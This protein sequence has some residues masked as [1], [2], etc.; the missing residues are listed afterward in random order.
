MGCCLRSAALVDDVIFGGLR[1]E[2]RCALVPKW[3][4]P[5]TYRCCVKDKAVREVLARSKAVSEDEKQA[6]ILTDQR[7]PIRSSGKRSQENNTL[8]SIGKV[9]L[10]AYNNGMHSYAEASG[11][12]T[13]PRFAT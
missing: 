8:L 1:R 13:V 5:H 3:L 10:E 2:K 12:N 11:A 7:D 6:L 9:S 4:Q